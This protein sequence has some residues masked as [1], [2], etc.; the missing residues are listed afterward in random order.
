MHDKVQK[1]EEKKMEN[2]LIGAKGDTLC[3]AC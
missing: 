3:P 1:K 2:K